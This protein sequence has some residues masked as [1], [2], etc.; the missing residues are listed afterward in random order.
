MSGEDITILVTQGWINGLLMGVK[1]LAPY[2]IGFCLIC[3]IIGILKGK[4]KKKK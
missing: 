4:F 2:I 1:I 3:L